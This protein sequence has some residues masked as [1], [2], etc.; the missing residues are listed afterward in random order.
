MAEKVKSDYAFVIACTPGY[1]FGMISAM[2][3][4]EHYGTNADWEIAYEWYTQEEREAISKAFKFNVNWT[5]IDDLMKLVNNRKKNPADN[6]P[7]YWMAYWLLAYKLLKEKK[8]KAVCVIQTD[9]FYMCNLDVYFKIAESGVFISGEY[10][11]YLNRL[12]GLPFGDDKAVWDRSQCA[13]FDS[14]NFLN[15]DYTELAIDTIRYQEVDVVKG[16]DN[17]SVIALNRAICKH[18]K[19]DKVL[20]LERNIWVCDTIW[21]DTVLHVDA[22]FKDRVYNDRGLQIFGWHCR[23]WQVGRVAA[24]WRNNQQVLHK[25]DIQEKNYILVRD[26]MA[27]FNNMKPEI[28]SKEYEDGSLERSI[29]LK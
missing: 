13:A 27:R 6:A 25:M 17:H 22:V 15:Q 8:Y 16:E 29:C 11:C 3:A 5:P 21:N 14:I 18:G 26:F 4:Q 28:S 20:S 24:E 9:S 1:G 10:P 12:E 7:K 19:K 2:N 23:W